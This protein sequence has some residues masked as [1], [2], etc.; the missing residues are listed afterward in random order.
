MDMAMSKGFARKMFHEDH[1]PR[2]D[3][4]ATAE[5]NLD[6]LNPQQKEAAL[7]VDGPVL[8]LAGAGSGKTKTLTYRIAHMVKN[9]GI[10]PYHIL[11]ITFTNKAAQEMKERVE[12]IIPGGTYGMWVCT[13]HAFCIRVLREHAHLLGYG[14]RLTIYDSDDQRRLIK[15]VLKDL[16]ID[17]DLPAS[18]AREIISLAK[19]EMKAPQDLYN[20]PNASMDASEAYEE[21][22]KRLVA[23][24][25]MD[26][27]DLL[28]KT[29]ELFDKFPEV[30]KRYQ[31]RFTYLSVDEYQDTNKV[32][33]LL[34]KQLAGEHK[35]I[36]VVGD[37]DQSI[38]SWRGADIR[39]ILDFE[40]DYPD[41]RV[42]MLE[43]NYRS[44]GNILGAANA[45][46]NKNTQRRAKKLFTDAGLGDKVLI[47]KAS[48]E[49]DEGT[50]VAAQINKELQAGTRPDDI[51]ILYRTNAQSRALEEMLNRAGIEYRLVGGVRFLD[52]AEIKDAVCY[53]R[54]VVNPSDELAFRRV[55]N[56]PRRGVGN[57][58]IAK[59]EEDAQRYG[60]SLFEAAEHA[61]GDTS[62]Y[63]KKVREGLA[64][65]T[66]L[67]RQAQ[68]W[69]EELP[70]L[71][72]RVIEVSG[73]IE[74]QEMTPSFESIGRVQ[75][76]KEFINMVA[77]FAE[78]QDDN[79]E[80]DEYERSLREE[81]LKRMAQGE[82][83]GL[84][85]LE[86]YVEWLALRTELEA[87]R[88]D[89]SGSRVTMMTVHSAKGLEFP[90]V[91]VVGLEEGIFPLRSMGA[92]QGVFGFDD[93]EDEEMA[94]ERR[95]AY[96]A[97]T[98]A[99]QKLR[100]SYADKRKVYGK[101]QCLPRS[102]FIA[103]IPSAYTGYSQIGSQGFSGT[104]WDKRGDRHGTAGSGSALYGGAVHGNTTRSSGFASS[105]GKESVGAS[106][107]GKPSSGFAQGS[108]TGSSSEYT[109]GDLINHKT[110]GKG[111][112]VEYDKAKRSICVCF[113]KTG[114]TKSFLLDFAPLVKIE[115]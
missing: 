37:D 53:L 42:V 13:F 93:D 83:P 63:S 7:S 108:S 100:L 30:L 81:R 115:G 77:E 55:V 112:V 107:Y 50:W 97:Y 49:R 68:E 64:E 80:L 72:R 57:T 113:E 90:I 35:N 87:A 62:R 1:G 110:M 75:N 41:A 12:Q 89:Q 8:V 29:V 3:T 39:N 51:A 99:K 24:S 98:R 66:S 70:E 91:F 28:Y 18:L 56:N 54:Q 34:C 17:D 102:R 2:L 105:R 76:L 95:L 84:L 20:D 88:S 22:Q 31:E 101:D 60:V 106:S 25:A 45:V 40:K 36:M 27:D 114:Q 58:S 86:A 103:D 109:V 33:Y 69:D 21:Y 23:A 9:L 78:D 48:D 43:Q 4:A 94:E 79:F 46:V 26:F 6:E 10:E 32:Q 44:T 14:E 82:R 71:A 19:N 111:K 52:K 104:G 85:E 61:V 11:A 96:V 16:A 15:A 47:Y 73:L 5:F 67:I 92:S 38:Y 74:A 59:L 65:Y